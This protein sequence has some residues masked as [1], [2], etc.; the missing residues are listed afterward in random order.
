[1]STLGLEVSFAIV[2]ENST[3]YYAWEE[4]SDGS[5]E[6]D[7]KEDPLLDEGERLFTVQ[8][9]P[10]SEHIRVTATNS[11]RLAEEALASRSNAG[12][13]RKPLHLNLV[14]STLRYL[15]AFSTQYKCL[16]AVVPLRKCTYINILGSVSRKVQK[17]TRS[18]D[19]SR[20][21][22]SLT[23]VYKAYFFRVNYIGLKCTK[24]DTSDSRT[25]ISSASVAKNA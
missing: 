9:Q 5:N 25:Y 14:T 12:H 17:S 20:C 1:M 4:T 18:S 22:R 15:G 10:R 16:K 3:V 11:Q 13:C 2:R 7:G 6:G 21:F 19:C 23:K 24:T 8:C